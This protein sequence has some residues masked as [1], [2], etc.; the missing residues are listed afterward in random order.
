MSPHGAKAFSSAQRLREMR[1]CGCCLCDQDSLRDHEEMSDSHA[2]MS[3]R[4]RILFHG[5]AII[6]CSSFR[7]VGGFFF[8]SQHSLGLVLIVRCGDGSV[9]WDV[10]LPE[11][12]GAASQ[13]GSVLP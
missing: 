9:S 2:I 7:A 10:V 11:H 1:L 5:H 4:M 13:S 12:P 8:Y 3:V 6:L